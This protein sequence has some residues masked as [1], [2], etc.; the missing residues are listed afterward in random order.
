[1]IPFGPK[2]VPEH[3]WF[4]SKPLP[5]RLLIMIA[6]VAMNVLLSIV[7]L[8]GIA[9]Y[10]GRTI[11]P[12]TVIGDVNPVA[13]APALG[14]LQPGD[15]IRSV[16]G[17]PVRSWN[18]V[19]DRIDSVR[20]GAVV[21]ETQRGR[22]EV[23]VGAGGAKTGSDVGEALDF[24]VPPVLDSVVPDHPAARAGLRKG[25]RILAVDGK[26]VSTW[27]SLVRQVSAAPGRP[28]E[29]QV[30]R[31][32]TVRRFAIA[33]ESTKAP[34][35]ETGNERIVGKIGALPL[36]VSQRERVDVG[37]ALS[38]GWN[39]TWGLAGVVIG[40][41]KR[42]FTG[43]LSVRSL[44]GPVAITSASVQ[45]ARN[46]MYELLRL[47]AFLSIN[48]AVLNMLPIP[49]LDGGQIVLNVV[50][51]VKGSPFSSRTREYILRFGLAAIALL[52]VIVMWNDLS[53]L[54]GR[55]FG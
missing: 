34:D 20:S 39:G 10:Y 44:G 21:I 12:S 35:P 30:Q 36:D 5:A 28:L 13:G 24:F 18:Q 2:P 33:P 46:G 40:F 55:L 29:F 50:E 53:G 11:V 47:I 17:A 27:Q 3:R 26:P 38:A 1:M 7:V 48:V 15:T 49:I 54:L 42:L 23:P 41:V 4:E 14:Q 16:G 9:L 43:E 31:G 22:V 19:R 6:G 32:G 25:D 52:F 51:S 8:T 45:A 37:D